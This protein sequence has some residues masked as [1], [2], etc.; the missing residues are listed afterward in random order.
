MDDV[1]KEPNV[2]NWIAKILLLCKGE[3]V[4]SLWT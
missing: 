2:E 4:K 1:K 3:R